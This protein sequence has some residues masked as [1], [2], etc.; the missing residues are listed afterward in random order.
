MPPTPDSTW[1]DGM[2]SL[3]PDEF[4]GLDELLSAVFRPGLIEQ[5]PHIYTPEN[6]PNLRVVV[7]NGKVVSHIGT[8]RRHASILGCTVKV[9]SLGGVGTLPEHRGQGYATALF[10]DTL[11][12]CRED[13]VDFVLVSGYRK[14]YHRYGCRYVGRDWNFTLPRARAVDFIDDELTVRPAR[15]Q[16]VPAM[17]SLYRREPV[18]WLRPP[19]DFH[20]ALNGY[21]MNRPNQVLTAWANQSLRAYVILQEQRPEGAGRVPLLEFA[22]ERRSLV[23]VLGRL[24]QDHDLE[25]LDVHVLG[26][27]SLLQELLQERGLPG[28]PTRASG[29]VVL[30]DSLQLMERLRP[31]FAEILG[32]DAAGLVFQERDDALV[33]SYGSDQVVA[34][35]RGAAAELVFGTLERREE[36][37]L[38]TGG[39]AGEVLRQIFPIPVL[40]CGMNYV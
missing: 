3:R 20:S 12:A 7:K 31:Y 17:A 37:L 24:I 6:A 40:W 10:A 28:Q 16:D 2:R 8:I 4:P 38:Q 35:D 23:G 1:R 22:G 11:R 9:A 29:T 14:L 25:A 26:Y 33:F 18:R 34:P 13:G 19:S 21:V 36:E 39:P 32:P 27:D 5:Y 30:V 15:T